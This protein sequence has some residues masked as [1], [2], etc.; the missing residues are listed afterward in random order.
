MRHSHGRPMHQIIA[1]VEAKAESEP[2]VE[3]AVKGCV[4]KATK[5]YNG[6]GFLVC[7]KHYDI[8][9]DEFDEEYR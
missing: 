3:C 9:N 1:E 4:E 2:I 7:D 5:D 6:H 8:L